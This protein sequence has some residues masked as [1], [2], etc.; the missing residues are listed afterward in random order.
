MGQENEEKYRAE[1]KNYKRVAVKFIGITLEDIT[2]H[3][4]RGVSCHMRTQKQEQ[5]QP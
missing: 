5:Q 2:A 3:K 1:Y 4:D